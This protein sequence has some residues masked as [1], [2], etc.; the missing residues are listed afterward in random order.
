MMFSKIKCC[1][2]VVKT[3]AQSVFRLSDTFTRVADIQPLHCHSD[4][5]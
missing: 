2:G 3:L 5:Q 1:N 4:A